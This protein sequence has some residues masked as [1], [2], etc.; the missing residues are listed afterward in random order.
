MGHI[1]E[2][3]AVASKEDRAG[4]GAIAYTDDIALK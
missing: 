1:F 2:P 4:S 3:L